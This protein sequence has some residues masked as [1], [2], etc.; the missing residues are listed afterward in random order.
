MFFVDPIHTSPDRSKTNGCVKPQE[1]GETLQPKKSPM[2]GAEQKF[3][4]YVGWSYF[5][6]VDSIKCALFRK[7]VGF[8][9]VC[10]YWK[11][12]D[13]RQVPHWKKKHTKKISEGWSYKEGC[14]CKDA[15]RET[16]V[17][18]RCPPF[19]WKLQPAPGTLQTTH[20]Q[21]AYK[22]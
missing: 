11:A 13:F 6:A 4:V 10:G 18:A 21:P 9:E 2:R 20:V 12:A 1:A 3:C 5:T 7:N 8:R 16:P 22:G 14:R 19:P 15:N 17:T